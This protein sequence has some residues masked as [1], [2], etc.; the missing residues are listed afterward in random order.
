M[1]HPWWM[2]HAQTF[3]D[4]TDPPGTAPPTGDPPS[5]TDPPAADPADP[6]DEEDRYKRLRR[7][8]GREVKKER[9]ARIAAEARLKEHDDAEAERA[10]KAL[11]EKGD[12]EKL[13]EAW[14]TERKALD[15]DREALRAKV[16]ATEAAEKKRIELLTASNAERVKALTGEAKALLDRLMPQLT[17]DGI[18]QELDIQERAA[19]RMSGGAFDRGARPP[20]GAPGVEWQDEV[21]G[22]H[23]RMADVQFGRLPP[24]E[25]GVQK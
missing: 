5:A 11:E 4:S 20:A 25:R 23:A 12:Y 17:P 10:R 15:A 6:D 22:G 7:S 18:A 8:L 16:E 14:E 1:T 19:Q 24:Q 3:F 13:R 9:D 2:P 21:K